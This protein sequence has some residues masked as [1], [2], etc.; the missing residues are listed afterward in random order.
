M[1]ETIVLH[2]KYKGVLRL[3][4]DGGRLRAIGRGIP[5][6][7]KVYA[8]IND[9][10]RLISENPSGSIKGI[11]VTD[12]SNNIIMEGRIRYARGNNSLAKAKLAFLRSNEHSAALNYILA[13]TEELFSEAHTSSN[14]ENKYQ[15]QKMQDLKKEPEKQAVQDKQ[16]HRIQNKS[17]YNPFAS[18][19]PDSEWKKVFHRRDR[20]FHI[21]GTATV[22]G[23]RLSIIA[24]PVK[25][26]SEAYF[27]AN[28]FTKP[29]VADDGTMCRMRI[30]RIK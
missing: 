27:N 16:L 17:A 19:Y 11:L 8:V 22:G 9:T 30:K 25:F 26:Y 12:G 4:R 28:G 24:V 29:V 1:A 2:G 18:T 10:P 13:R 20:G 6:D 23:E 15:E 14:S 3:Y 5:K 21:V 7:S